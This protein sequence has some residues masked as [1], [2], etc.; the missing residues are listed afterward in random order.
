LTVH[1]EELQDRKSELLIRALHAE[2]ATQLIAGAIYEPADGDLD[3][4][5]SV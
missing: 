1:A 4:A 5:A 2:R 3:A